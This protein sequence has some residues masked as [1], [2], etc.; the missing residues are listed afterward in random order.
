MLSFKMA[1]RTC[2][3]MFCE[4]A[5]KIDC[6]TYIHLQSGYF[7][8]CQISLNNEKIIIFPI[9]F[10][11]S[12]VLTR[13]CC[14]LAICNKI[15]RFAAF[16]WQMIFVGYHFRALKAIKLSFP[17]IS[18][19]CKKVPLDSQKPFQDNSAKSGP[20]HIFYAKSHTLLQVDSRTNNLNEF[21][22]DG[23]E[24]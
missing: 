21:I 13:L 23:H 15:T 24:K 1:P 10:Y 4:P 17:L 19:Q 11:K 16:F 3:Q 8:Y 14:Y 20:F 7:G 18:I 22:F 6:L 5:D 9:F 12:G 2:I